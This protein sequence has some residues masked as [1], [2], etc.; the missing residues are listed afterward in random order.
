MAIE[1]KVVRL[2]FAALFAHRSVAIDLIGCLAAHVTSDSA[3]R[4]ALTTAFGEAFNNV[5]EHSYRDRSDGLLDVEAEISQTCLKLTLTDSGLPADLT[6][7]ALPD[8]ATLPEG[9]M[10][11]YMMHSFVDEVV[12]R[13]GSPN[14][15]T[16]TKWTAR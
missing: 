12:Y 5:V 3:F 9:G 6:A 15:L 16:L 4:D 7:V 13:A 10:G 14:V 2:Q 8:L 1:P 11:L